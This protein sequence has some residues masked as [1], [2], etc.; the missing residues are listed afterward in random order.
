[1]II[2]AVLFVILGWLVGIAINHAADILPA[3]KTLRQWPICVA[4]E[5]PR[6]RRQWSALLAWL[7]GQQQCMTCGRSRPRPVRSVIVELVTPLVFGF[8]WWRYGLSL[9]LGLISLYSA[10]LILVTVTDLEH[11][12]IFNVIMLPSILLAIGAVFITPGLTWRAGLVGGVFAFIVVYVA[13]LLS[14]GGLGEGDVTLSTFL[15]FVM[16]FPHIIL[17]LTFGVFLGGIVAFLLLV[18]GRV[19]MKTFIPYGPFLTVTGWIMLVWGAEIWAYY[20][21]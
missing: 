17:S 12:L 7:S 16:G 20:F 13:V 11:R 14:R 8:L 21:W 15:G 3:R 9:K 1:M 2:L 19:G 4:C 6:P 5:A 18:T 10:I